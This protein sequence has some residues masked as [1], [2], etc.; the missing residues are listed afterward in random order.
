[1]RGLVLILSSCLATDWQQ[2]SAQ[3]PQAAVPMTAEPGSEANSGG[4]LSP[5]AEMFEMDSP[6]GISGDGS[7]L[8]AD[9]GGSCPPSWYVQGEALYFVNAGN[10]PA[11]LSA[12]Y[13]LPEFS[14]EL[15]LRLTV[16]RRWDCSEALEVSYVGPLKWEVA[17]EASGFPLN[18]RFAVPNGDVNISAFNG[19]E[20]HRQT[21]ESTLHSVEINERYFD[22]D[23]MSCLV[24]ARYIDFEEGFS[25]ETEGPAPLA[26]QGLYTVG[27]RNRLIGPQCGLDVISP[28]GSSNRLSLIAKTKLGVYANL[29]KDEVRLVNA[30]VQ[31]LDN[32]SNDVS[33]AF[34][35]ELGALVNLRITRHLSVHCGYELWYLYGLAL[36]DGQT[37]SP[38]TQATGTNLEADQDTWFHGVTLGGQIVW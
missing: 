26:E 23:T 8:P 29:A 7:V 18:S 36:A 24:G 28:V 2:A 6:N 10:G 37:F 19:A 15:G 35:G 38:L 20:Y 16:G 5:L 30:G 13:A 14:N 1:V 3:E 25:F 12:A 9:C 31:E 33:L 34:Q 21:Y 22:W 32:N 27:T 4:P 17:A 11:S